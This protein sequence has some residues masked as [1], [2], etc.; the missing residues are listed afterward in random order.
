M[1]YLNKEER[2]KLQTELKKMSF[3]K[4]KFKLHHMDPKA[5]LAFYRNV[6]T[7]GKWMTRFELPSL[8][9]RVT[10]IENYDEATRDNKIKSEYAMVDVLVEPTADNRN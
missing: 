4:A 8:G 10:L 2:E 1:N 5:R 6:Q 7:V 9:T 3:N